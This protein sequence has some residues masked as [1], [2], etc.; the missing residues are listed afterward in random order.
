MPVLVLVLLVLVPV[1]VLVLVLVLVVVLVL[2]MGFRGNFDVHWYSHR[3]FLHNP[4]HSRVRVVVAHVMLVVSLVTRVAMVTRVR[5]MLAVTRVVVTVAVVMVTWMCVLRII[6]VV[7]VTMRK[8]VTALLRRLCV[9]SEYLSGAGVRSGLVVRV[10][11][12]G[13]NTRWLSIYSPL[14]PG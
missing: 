6:R 11:L 5:A 9:S 10:R 1:P 14:L 7:M 4:F 3:Y 12:M 13:I 2:V 8:V